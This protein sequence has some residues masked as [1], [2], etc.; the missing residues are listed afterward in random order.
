MSYDY[1]ALVG[2]RPTGSVGQQIVSAYVSTEKPAAAT[3][4]DPV[5]V[6]VPAM[7]TEVSLPLPWPQS[8]GTTPPGQG[9][10]LLVAYDENRTPHI[11]VWF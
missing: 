6:V 3:T 7:S 4:D 2:G 10:Q 1:R 8:L 5:Y 9:D 11:I